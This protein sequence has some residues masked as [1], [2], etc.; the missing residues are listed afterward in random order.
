MTLVWASDLGQR[1]LTTGWRLR[2]LRPLRSNRRQPR[3]VGEVWDVSNYV[4][5]VRSWRVGLP[6]LN[7]GRHCQG[8]A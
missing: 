7:V 2:G 6:A 3:R 5:L 1:R 8:R 4:E